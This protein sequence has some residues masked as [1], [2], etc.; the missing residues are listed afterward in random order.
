MIKNINLDQTAP[1]AAFD[2]CLYYFQFHH[3]LVHTLNC[4]I[5]LTSNVIIPFYL[6]N[7]PF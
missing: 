6:I 1:E 7:A 4:E 2:Q 5:G 3:Y